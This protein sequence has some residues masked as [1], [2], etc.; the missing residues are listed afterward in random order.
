MW[1]YLSLVFFLY[2]V[3][4]SSHQVNSAAEPESVVHDFFEILD[5]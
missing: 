4:D 5:F 2:F 3:L 1:D